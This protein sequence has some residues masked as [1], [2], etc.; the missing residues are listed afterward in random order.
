MHIFYL[1][2]RGQCY[3]Y[4]AREKKN[5]IDVKYEHKNDTYHHQ[6]IQHHHRQKELNYDHV[7]EMSK[8]PAPRPLYSNFPVKEL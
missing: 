2:S 4:K 5:N 7:I 1:L 8:N 3:I 6:K